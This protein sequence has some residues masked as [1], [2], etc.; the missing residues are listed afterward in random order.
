MIG[1]VM[2]NMSH[3]IAGWTIRLVSNPFGKYV[4]LTKEL[5]GFLLKEFTENWKEDQEELLWKEQSE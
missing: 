4:R 3:K 2:Q 1:M 5:L